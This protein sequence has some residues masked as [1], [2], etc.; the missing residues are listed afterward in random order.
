MAFIEN[1]STKFGN[2]IPPRK[3]NGVKKMN[4]SIIVGGGVGGQ[5]QPQPQLYVDHI[6]PIQVCT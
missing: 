3:R 1:S 2:I 4:C 6:V 5:S